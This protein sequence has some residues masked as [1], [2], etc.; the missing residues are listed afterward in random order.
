MDPQRTTYS[1]NTDEF[2]HEFR[3]ILLQL[4]EFI[5]NNDEMRQ[6]LGLTLSEQTIIFIDML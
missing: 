6:G 2:I 4:C 5:N 3:L 1:R